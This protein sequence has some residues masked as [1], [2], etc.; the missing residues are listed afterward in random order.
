MNEYEK[1]CWEIMVDS[2]LTRAPSE[3]IPT[4]WKYTKKIMPI[5]DDILLVKNIG[6]KYQITPVIDVDFNEQ[7]DY[8]LENI[9]KYKKVLQASD[10]FKNYIKYMKHYEKKPKY[11]LSD[12]F[13]KFY[14]K[15]GVTIKVNVH[16]IR[17][18]K[19]FSIPLRYGGFRLVKKGTLGGYIQNE[20]NLSQQGSCWIDNLSLVIDNARIEDDA[21]IENSTI[22][23]FAVVKDN[24]SCKNSKICNNAHIEKTSFIANSI[25][26]D[27]CYV[28]D[29]SMINDSQLQG[30]LEI[31]NSII[32][33][34]VCSEYLR[35]RDSEIDSQILKG[36]RLIKNKKIY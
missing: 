27:N 9:E 1:H 11:V 29:T 35:I 30:D 24:V 2:A 5:F 28:T 20:K 14:A 19:D 21:Q 6:I 32:N 22:S 23:D 31:Y 10:D 15:K 26:D 16:K 18:N 8:V 17:A 36:C 25:V 33:S 7:A 4:I 13:P 12:C 3:I 34:C